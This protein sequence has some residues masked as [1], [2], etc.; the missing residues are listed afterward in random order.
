MDT[1]ETL[2]RFED[3]VN[4]YKQELEG[5]SLERLLWKPSA[6][7]WSLGQMYMHLIGSAQQMQ[8]ANAALCLAPDGD[9]ADC[10]A[11]KTKQGEALFQEG[12]FP[13]DRIQVPPSPAYT[14]PQPA[15]K[16]QLLDGLRQT[17]SRMAEIEPAVAAAFDP[18]RDAAFQRVH[19]TVVHPRLGGLNALEWF[20]LIE[21]HYRHHRLQKQRL[22]DAWTKAHG[23]CGVPAGPRRI[24]PSWTERPACTPTLSSP[25]SPFLL[26]SPFS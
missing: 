14:P 10:P 5:L 9:P 15:G 18:Q 13:P 4:R 17:L 8:L 2:R 20:Q 19:K 3:T 11:G 16:E 24:S 25:F 7:E 1:K 22:D 6:D 12:S 26:Y 23:S 21:M